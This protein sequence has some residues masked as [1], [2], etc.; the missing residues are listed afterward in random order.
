M[1]N[2]VISKNLEYYCCLNPISL[3]ID[4]NNG[5]LHIADFGSPD[6]AN[7]KFILNGTFLKSLAD[8]N[9]EMENLLIRRE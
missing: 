2:K 3:E 8:F 6:F 7:K 1:S 9:W 5:F 4:R